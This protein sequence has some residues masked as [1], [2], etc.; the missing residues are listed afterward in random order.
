M[1]LQNEYRMLCLNPV[2]AVTKKFGLHEYQRCFNR[3]KMKLWILLRVLPRPP[4]GIRS[5]MVSLFL[6]SKDPAKV[7]P[8]WQTQQH[9]MQE[10]ADA[11]GS[12]FHRNKATAL[13]TNPIS[14]RIWK[15]IN[16][17]KHGFSNFLCWKTTQTSNS[18]LSI[19]LNFEWPDFGQMCHSFNVI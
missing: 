2:I 15:K 19:R 9:A 5:V 10:S 16:E 12:L 6:T 8:V 17:W 1:P 13:F 3:D 18:A 7:W 4:I 11:R 14:K